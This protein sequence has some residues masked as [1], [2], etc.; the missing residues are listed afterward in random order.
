MRIVVALGAAAAGIAIALPGAAEPPETH[1]RARAHQVV[2]ESTHFRRQECAADTR[3]GVRLLQQT[4]GICTR[5]QTWGVTAHS[6]WVTN[7]CR[8][9]FAVVPG[10]GGGAPPAGRLI[11]CEAWQSHRVRCAARLS[12]RPRI[13]VIAGSCSEGR[14]WGWDRAGIWVSRGCRARFLTDK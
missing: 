10:P 8:A 2:C 3:G 4:S 6:V 11:V 1:F 7:G 5:G 13:E 14:S 12:R 9:I